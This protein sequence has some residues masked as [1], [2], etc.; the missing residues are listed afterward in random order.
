M[1]V[2]VEMGGGDVA[3]C[4][5]RVG[6][7]VG[8]AG[9]A[10][11]AVGGSEHACRTMKAPNAA[12]ARM[13]RAEHDTGRPAPAP[14]RRPLR[15]AIARRPPFPFPQEATIAEARF[16]YHS[17]PVRLPLASLTTG[18]PSPAPPGAG[19]SPVLRAP[20]GWTGHPPH[21][22]GSRSRPPRRPAPDSASG[23][24]KVSRRRP[25]SRADGAWSTSR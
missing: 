10:G 18:A 13:L 17:M 15:E 21:R 16:R 23:T 19:P 14:R 8:E 22:A 4:E 2:G 7:G 20:P 3:A 1:P 24:W 5:G 12:P 9:S 25:T 11:P 6:R